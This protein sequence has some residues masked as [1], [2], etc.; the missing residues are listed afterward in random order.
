[1]ADL[2]DRY[3]V[4]VSPAAPAAGGDLFD[5]YAA[6]PSSG[7]V[8]DWE[9]S[10]YSG[11]QMAAR[12]VGLAAQGVNDA[13]LPTIIGAPVDAV[14]WGLRQAGIPVNDPV[15]GSKSIKRGIDYVATLPGRVSDAVSQGSI[16]PL[17]DSRTSRIEPVTT[18][19][20][21]AYGAGEGV[22]NVLAMTLPAGVVGRV[23]AP[24]SV[25]GGVANALATQPVLQTVAGATGGAVTGATDNPW[26]GLAAGVGVPLAA[27]GVQKAGKVGGSLLQPFTAGGRDAIVGK[28]LNT[29]ADDPTRAAE[30]MLRYRAPVDGFRLSAAKASGDD[31]LMATEN[32]L[33]R[34][35]TGFGERANANNAALTR[36]LDDLNAGGDPRA[37]I[38]ALGRLDAG[39]AM[40]AQA[41]LDALPPSVDPTTAGQAIQNALR[42]RFD[43][44]VTARSQAADPLYEAARASTQAVPALPLASLV[45]D[46]ARANK[47]E[48]RAAMERVRAL[49]FNAD[50]QL[51]RTASGMMAS[52]SA[53]GD[54]LDSPQ[55]GNNTRRL[56]LEVQRRLDDALA[57]VPEEQLARG[58]FAERSVPLN[59]FD[60]TRGNKTVAGAISQDR[61]SGAFLQTPEQVTGNFLRP[62]DAGTAAIRELRGTDTR[63]PLNAL[64]GVVAGRVRD[65]ASVENIRPAVNALSPRLGQQVDDVRTTNT[66]AQGFRSGPAG[67]FMTGD[68]D[69]AVKSTLGAPDSANRLQ[70][71]AMSVGDD[72]QAVAGLRRA[73]IDNF[74]TSA[75]S[76]VAEDAA[77]NPNLL[78]AGSARW[79]ESNREALR[80]I[81]TPD[82][83]SGLEA[84]TRALKDQARSATKVAGSDTGRNIA[85]QNIVESLLWKG[86]GDSAITAPLRKTLNLVYGGGSEK[87]A[88]RLAEVM[89]DPQVAAALMQRANVRNVTRATT[90]L[91]R[92]ALATAVG[93]NVETRPTN[94]LRAP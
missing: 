34:A 21:T 18:G 61:R 26:L 10:G 82:Q 65:G 37:F 28:T 38:A 20:R 79:L 58:V 43:A 59:P 74:R 19:E 72:P 92:A 27:V 35:G 11:G 17:T 25:T 4:A 56:L 78:A 66:L 32:A 31:S 16:N 81:L 9:P 30:N 52:R 60:A 40:R 62:G 54:M 57:A 83:L 44:L 51:D 53:I 69:A 85:T 39:A 80:G 63:V 14:A 13:F 36:A 55:I 76:A 46:L 90:A 68:L 29:L 24:G 22:G 50:G 48:P 12:K 23:A 5:R 70:A 77:G 1:M 7:G 3:G 45:D 42:G 8:Q 88:D 49:L 87:I 33:T 75:R 67:R 73:I 6:G 47:G 64:E 94:P 86:A 89:L 93:S 84:I 91:D 41:A 15:G 2:F 71:L